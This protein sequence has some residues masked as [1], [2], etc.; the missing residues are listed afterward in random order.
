MKGVFVLWNERAKLTGVFALDVDKYEDQLDLMQLETGCELEVVFKS[1]GIPKCKKYISDTLVNMNHYRTYG[2]WFDID[3]V[4]IQWLFADLL[5]FDFN[6][7]SAV[8]GRFGITMRSA[9][10]MCGVKYI[11]GSEL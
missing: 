3:C 4:D 10:R 7:A 11:P 1:P 6:N 5:V 9:Y 2:G 8:A